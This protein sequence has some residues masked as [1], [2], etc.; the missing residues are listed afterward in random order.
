MLSFR[1]RACEPNFFFIFLSLEYVLA[2]KIACCPRCLV[3]HWA[4]AVFLYTHYDQYDNA[5]EIM[6]D[7]SPSCWKN[8]LFKEIIVKVGNTEVFYRVC[9]D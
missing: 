7:H 1:L 9:C 8:D 2:A 5:I 4:E 3:G 6:M